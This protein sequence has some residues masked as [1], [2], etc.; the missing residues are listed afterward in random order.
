VAAI[1]VKQMAFREILNYAQASE[2]HKLT[3]IYRPTERNKPVA[4]HCA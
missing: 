4:G 2:I 1:N 3:G